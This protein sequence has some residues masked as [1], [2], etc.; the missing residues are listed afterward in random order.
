[1]TEAPDLQHDE[2]R[3]GRGWF[4]ALVVL[5]AFAAAGALAGVVW[6]WVWSP[7][8]GV[9][10]QRQW[11]LDS[12]G[13]RDSFSGTGTYVVVASLTGIVMGSLAGFLFDRSE[14][15]T[16]AAV[17]VGGL[18]AAWLM[19]QVGEALGPPDPDPIAATSKNYTPI[20]GNLDVSGRSPWVAFPG[21]A[22]LGLIVVLLGLKGRRRSPVN[23][24]ADE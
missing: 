4:D 3:P 11:V 13:L 8:S 19:Q 9:A 20:P 7:P 16:L 17:A 5:A 22:L 12:D 15:A 2:G 6:E 24:P 23:A 14:L 18:L 10:L 1:M 21:G